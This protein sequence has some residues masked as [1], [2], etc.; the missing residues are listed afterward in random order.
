MRCEL[1]CL[2]RES[3]FSSGE[4]KF[5]RKTLHE[6]AVLDDEHDDASDYSYREGFF[7][8]L[9]LPEG[10]VLSLPV[11]VEEIDG[12]RYYSAFMPLPSGL[13]APFPECFFR[14]TSHVRGARLPG[15]FLSAFAPGVRKDHK[16]RI[17]VPL[18]DARR[19]LQRLRDALSP[20]IENYAGSIGKLRE[21]APPDPRGIGVYYE[22]DDKTI[23]ESFRTLPPESAVWYAIRRLFCLF[24][25]RGFADAA[26]WLARDL[27]CRSLLRLDYHEAAN[28]YGGGLGTDECLEKGRQYFLAKFESVRQILEALE[29]RDW[30]ALPGQ[31]AIRDADESEYDIA[32]W[33]NMCEFVSSDFVDYILTEEERSRIT[34]W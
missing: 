14:K 2:F 12:Q 29:R 13:R 23:T 10:A 19:S 6:L 27:G 11:R 21:T 26:A 9:G 7:R 18:A 4:Q 31:L 22:T 25:A 32:R 16:D 20:L 17:F 24:D 1:D 33:L 15:A 28:F 8:N 30:A 5:L 3:E 34:V